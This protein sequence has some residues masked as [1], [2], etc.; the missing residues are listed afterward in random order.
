MDSFN[1]EI[2][3]ANSQNISLF[4]KREDLLHPEISGNKFRKLKY[5]LVEAQSEGYSKL[6]TFGGAF[7][8]HIA[9]VAAAGKKYGFETVGVIRGEELSDRISDNPTLLSAQKNG[10]KFVFVSREQFRKKDS[11]E[12]LKCLR[13]EYHDFYFLPEGGTNA[14]AIKGCAEILTNDDVDFTHVCCAVGTGGT[15]SGIINSASGNQ[16]VLGF[17][18]LKGSFLSDDIR[19]FVKNTNWELISDYHFGGYG[20]INEE[21]IRFLNEFYE[22]TNIPLDPVYTGKMMF[23][24]H[25]LIQ[26][27]NLPP[28]SRI[29]AIHTGGLQGVQGMNLLLKKKRLPLLNYI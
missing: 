27:G 24:I 23:G 4:I 11:L 14:L 3:L 9:A 19:S 22:T 12:F 28:G 25:D 18:A 5:N 17:P 2:K 10:M 8:N 6:L 13:E 20:K 1:Q 16:K 21:L 15:L 29:L 7:S 26:K